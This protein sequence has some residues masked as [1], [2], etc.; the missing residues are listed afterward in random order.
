MGRFVASGDLTPLFPD[1]QAPFRL[2]QGRL[3]AWDAGTLANT[4]TVFGQP[5]S[6]LPI[7]DQAVTGMSA[8]ITVVLAP[9]GTTYLIIDKIRVPA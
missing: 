6:N 5:R 1:A 3:T 2:I 4:V 8:G 9:F 7:L